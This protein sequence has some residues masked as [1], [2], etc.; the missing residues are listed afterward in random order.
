MHSN[1]LCKGPFEHGRLGDER[2]WGVF[3]N[4]LQNH[5]RVGRLNDS[6]NTREG[7]KG[8]GGL[9]DLTKMS[10][11]KNLHISPLLVGIYG[12]YYMILGP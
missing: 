12:N 11:Y 1:L 4:V 6:G 7:G 5:I 9:L 3:Y 10:C 8:M 2:G